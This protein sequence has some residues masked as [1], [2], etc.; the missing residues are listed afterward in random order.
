MDHSVKLPQHIELQ[1]FY[2]Y[3]T[4]DYRVYINQLL[5]DSRDGQRQGFPPHIAK[6]LFNLLQEHDREFPQ[7]VPQLKP[8]DIA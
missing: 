2:L 3:A 7:F 1:L 8:W 4:R 5:Q 6:H